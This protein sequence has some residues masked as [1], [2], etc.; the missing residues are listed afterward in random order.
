MAQHRAHYRHILNARTMH[1]YVQWEDA[2]DH[3]PYAVP[4]A[5]SRVQNLLDSMVNSKDYLVCTRLAHITSNAMGMLTD[6]N[7][8]VAHLLSSCPVARNYQEGGRWAR[9]YSV[10][11]DGAT[12]EHADC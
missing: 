6:F 5:K 12:T 1:T 4:Q 7:K 10:A 9:V 2:N 3:V 8:V 11:N